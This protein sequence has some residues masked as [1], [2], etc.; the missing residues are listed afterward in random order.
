MET[1][2][3][4]VPKSKVALV[5]AVL[6]ELGVT[7]KDLPKND[8]SAYKQKIAKIPVWSDEDLKPIEEARKTSFKQA[9]A[10]MSVWTDED[11]KPIEERK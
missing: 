8:L 10:N 9:L 2:V 5:K 6:K 4:N 1:L 11:I 3:I 7:I